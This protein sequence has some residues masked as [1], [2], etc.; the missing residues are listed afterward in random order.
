MKQGDFSKLAKDY[1]NRPGYSLRLLNNIANIP[2][3]SR[4]KFK[5]ADIGAGTGKLSESF[6]TWI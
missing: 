3:S 5:V 4:S 6:T 2:I 1:I